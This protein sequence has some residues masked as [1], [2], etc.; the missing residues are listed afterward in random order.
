MS[1][2]DSLESMFI[3]VYVEIHSEITE[4]TTTSSIHEIFYQ[5]I[6]LSLSTL[7]ASTSLLRRLVLLHP[8]SF[9]TKTPTH[10]NTPPFLFT[11]SVVF[12]LG[13]YIHILNGYTRW[14]SSFLFFLFLWIDLPI[15]LLLLVLLL[16]YVL[17]YIHFKN[18]KNWIMNVKTDEKN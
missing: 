5:W 18:H 9:Y 14:R 7:H 1:C 15:W 17:I 10:S 16:V 4:F 6:D 2:S 3:Y 12:G 11:N 13:I 8:S